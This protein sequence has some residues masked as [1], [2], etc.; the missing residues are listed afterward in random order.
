MRLLGFSVTFLGILFCLWLASVPISGG[1]IRPDTR[2][3][4]WQFE[5]RPNI[6]MTSS[7]A[8]GHV[9]IR[10][11]GHFIHIGHLDVYTTY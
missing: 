1:M 11:R 10:M 2:R 9:N 5:A 7:A 3:E 8:G 6:A 4:F